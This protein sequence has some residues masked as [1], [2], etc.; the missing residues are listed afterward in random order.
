MRQKTPQDP[1]S[2]PPRLGEDWMSV[3]LGLAIV[4]VVTLLGLTSIP[5]PL[6]GL[7]E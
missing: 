5:W 6:L 4:L 1:S 3:V 2:S 7:F